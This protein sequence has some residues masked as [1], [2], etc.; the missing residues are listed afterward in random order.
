MVS[1]GLA[2][3]LLAGDTTADAQIGSLG[4]QRFGKWFRV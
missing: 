3:V 2:H 1:D 4:P